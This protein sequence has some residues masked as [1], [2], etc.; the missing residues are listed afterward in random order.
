MGGTLGTVVTWPLA[1]I[2]VETMG[3]EYAFYIPALFTSFITLLWF[4]LVADTPAKHSNITM[5]EKLYIENS[6]E[7]NV[8]RHKN[9][10][11]FNTLNKHHISIIIHS[12]GFL[13]FTTRYVFVHLSTILGPTVIALWKLM[14]F[15]LP[16]NSSP[17]IHEWSKYQINHSTWKYHSNSPSSSHILQILKF[18]FSNAG[19]LSS[20]PYL[21]RMINGFIFGVVGDLVR[22]NSSLN[23]TNIRKMFCI[24]C[25]FIYLKTEKNCSILFPLTTLH[26]TLDKTYFR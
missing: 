7:N 14:G 4:V 11:V 2:I 9:V 26:M 3:W 6:L 13:G 12:I 5:E 23:V 17:K 22:R 10:S 15:E 24:C 8:V 25:K 21:V 19:I 20:L 16:H 1:G 18:N